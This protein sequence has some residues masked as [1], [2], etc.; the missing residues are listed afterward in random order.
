MRAL[1]WL[2]AAALLLGPAAP[3]QTADGWASQD[4]GT[5]GG[6]AAAALTVTSASELR[7]ALAAGARVIEVA[8]IIDMR[9]GQPFASRA[10]QL[11][12]GTIRVPSDTTLTGAGTGSGLMHAS[13]LLNKVSNVIIRKLNL[14][15]PCDVAPTWDPQ[16]GSKGN[17]NAQLDA[18]AV[19]ASRRVWI[20]R[21]S[22]TDAPHGDELAPLENGMPKQCHD[23]ALDINQ[24]SDLVTVSYNRF[25]LH[26]KNSLVGSSDNATGDLGRLRVTFSNNLFEYISSRAPRVRFG[27]VHLYNNY[28]LGAR[29][30]PVYQHQ[31]SVGVGK[32]ADII[33]HANV[34]EIDGARGCGDVV[35]SHG[36]DNSFTDAGSTLN[37]A[38]LAGCALPSAPAWQVPYPFTARPAAQVKQHVLDNAGAGNWQFDSM[39]DGA[40]LALAAAGSPLAAAPADFYLEARIGALRPASGKGQLVLLGR[41]RAGNWT[42]AGLALADGVLEVNVVRMQ[43]GVPTRVKQFRRFEASARRSDLLRVE[44]G[45][46][47]LTVYLNGEKLG[48]VNDARF[49]QGGAQVGFYSQGNAFDIDQVR[50]GPAA[51]KPARIALSGVAGVLRA[52]VGD[53]PLTVPVS[54]VGG[55][56][57]TRIAFTARSDNPLVASVVA[58]ALGVT[59]VPAG[60]GEAR[61]L[62]GSPTDPSQQAWFGVK[63]GPRFNMPPARSPAPVVFPPAGARGVPVDTPL[64]LTFAAPPTLGA[65][66]SVRIYRKRD[67][68][69]VDV[70]RPGEEVARMG[71]GKAERLRH[72]R[73]HPI[74]VAGRSATI[75]SHAGVLAYDT[76]YLVAVG[77]GVFDDAVGRW[78]FRTRKDMG[79]R[80]RLV[81]DDDGPADF[82][83]VQGALD[84]AMARYPKAAPLTIAIGNG[85]YEE[86]LFLRA[87]DRVTLRGESRDGVV[88]HAVNNDG[89]HSG[90]GAS[91]APGAPGVGGGRALFL[92]E[93]LDLLTLETLTLRNDSER[94]YSRSGQAETIYFNSDAGRLVARDASFFSEQDTLQL[95]GYAWFYRTLVA[96][97][98][99]FIWGANRAALFE[100][101]EIRS[102]GDSANP[103]SGGYI[104]QA[105][106]V[107][108]KDPGFVF[109]DSVLTHGVGPAGNPVL[110]GRTYL[111]RSPG[112][113][114]TWDNVSFIN[115]RMD[116]HIAPRGWAGVGVGREPVPNPARADALHGWREHGSADLAGTALD[117]RP[118][119]G[120]YV[121]DAAERDSRFGGRA[122]VFAGFNGGEGWNPGSVSVGGGGSR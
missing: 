92:A 52:Q 58:G 10:D 7:A 79:A 88:I 39:P 32:Q 97:N 40:I 43:D 8:G 46:S 31:Y 73:R 13:L 87:R 105:R 26:E 38:A 35:R 93:E 70:I 118:R 60:P 55:D 114:N 96:G 51:N 104:V 108:A 19:S 11:K 34:Y 75:E 59:V 44:L 119:I 111:A 110:P 76:E 63:V 23:G 103:E 27:R 12:R 36:A 120:G 94:R 47:A 102:V 107:S 16:D 41:H 71:P 54:A 86:L 84:H 15:N 17:W 50:A 49:A 25:A 106:T 115:C 57:A 3:A 72:V 121:L 91:A 42:G 117:L 99:D 5:T 85:S 100:Q 109:L 20:D 24:G 74:R 101:S 90:S 83:T 29:R 21:N 80:A 64:R 33:A 30:H 68:A 61:V 6:G 56:G 62:L 14:R 1:P 66:G 81:V 122:S 69:L 37:G 78:S 4:G 98:V 48:T 116:A 77:A 67:M 18:I 28:H 112:T 53:A 82:R 89:I 22:F 9:E 95:K 2:A 45:G 65:S 113:A